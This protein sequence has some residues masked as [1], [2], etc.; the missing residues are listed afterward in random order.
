MRFI[1]RNL[2]HYYIVLQTGIFLLR[3]FS[4]LS[5][6]RTSVTVFGKRFPFSRQDTN[7]MSYFTPP[8]TPSRTK[9]DKE[10][11]IH[12]T[13]YETWKS[14]CRKIES[15]PHNCPHIIRK[16]F[17]QIVAISKRAEKMDT[18]ALAPF[19]E[20]MEPLFT[21]EENGF[22]Q[23]V[24]ERQYMHLDSLLTE[25][26]TH[27]GSI[28][29]LSTPNIHSARATRSRLTRRKTS[30]RTR[31]DSKDSK[32]HIV[33]FV[34]TAI[35]ILGLASLDSSKGYQDV[36]YSNG[37]DNSTKV[38]PVPPAFSPLT[39]PLEPGLEGFLSGD[40]LAAELNYSSS[41]K[42]HFTSTASQDLFLTTDL[43]LGPGEFSNPDA[44]YVSWTS[45]L[46]ND[47]LMPG[48]SEDVQAYP[49]I[50]MDEEGILTTETP[51]LDE[52]FEQFLDFGDNEKSVC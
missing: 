19:C 31:G 5:H 2:R 30:Q 16:I 42:S 23:Y 15:N 52:E 3:L 26:C 11:S 7:T 4:L 40:E 1:V 34:A 25:L 29:N 22:C 39:P 33:S 12:E 45:L 32:Y 24:H 41:K 14:I 51:F 9:K 21:S 43:K 46:F 35:Q 47:F 10:P 27:L 13:T 38:E 50:S 36:E 37:G 49:D 6:P 17:N 20:D 28:Q 8:T 44:K 18:V 48:G